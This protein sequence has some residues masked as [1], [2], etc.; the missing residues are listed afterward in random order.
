MSW[1]NEERCI[2]QIRWDMTDDIPEDV[3]T[4]IKEEDISLK[5][6]GEDFS[7]YYESKG[8]ILGE[9]DMNIFGYTF[10]HFLDENTS[11]VED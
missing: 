6:L 3:M 1:K 11:Y 7:D 4:F 8:N 9:V 10:Q 5:E 2:F